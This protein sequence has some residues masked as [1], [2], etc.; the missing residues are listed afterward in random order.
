MCRYWT[1]LPGDSVV[2]NQPANEEDIGDSGVIPG[3]GRPPGGGNATHSSVLA[4]RIPWSETLGCHSPW[5]HRE[6]DMIQHTPSHTDVGYGVTCGSVQLWEKKRLPTCLP[7]KVCF[8]EEKSSQSFP[9][10]AQLRNSQQ[11]VF[12]NC[13]PPDGWSEA[14]LCSWVSSPCGPELTPPQSV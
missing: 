11:E 5:G 12:S 1:G 9:E 10:K 4:W 14:S 8:Q 6:S 7:L 13:S 2:K 3:P